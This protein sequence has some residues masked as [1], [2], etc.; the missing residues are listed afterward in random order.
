M[1]IGNYFH[2]LVAEHIHMGAEFSP[3]LG[4]A[5]A[6]GLA[7]IMPMRAVDAHHLLE[8]RRFDIWVTSV[9]LFYTL[10]SELAKRKSWC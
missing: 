7:R 8:A 10:K 5:V 3:L 1:T 2:L 4:L 9:P 6:W